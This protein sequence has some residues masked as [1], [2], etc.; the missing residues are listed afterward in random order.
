MRK[1]W[2]P[3]C[4]EEAYEAQGQKGPILV[5]GHPGRAGDLVRV[6]EACGDATSVSNWYIHRCAEVRFPPK[7]NTAAMNRALEAVGLDPVKEQ[8]DGART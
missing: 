5:T 6:K 2:C 7:R 1:A 8:G 4:G 3:R